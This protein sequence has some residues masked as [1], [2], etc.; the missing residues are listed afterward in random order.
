MLDA[1]ATCN[2][3]GHGKPFRRN[4]DE[5]ALDPDE[6]FG[7]ECQT[8]ACVECGRSTGEAL[9]YDR[10]C[11]E[12]RNN[13]KIEG[14]T[15]DSN[16]QFEQRDIF[17]GPQRYPEPGK[18][19]KY[20]PGEEY[21]TLSYKNFEIKIGY[22]YFNRLV[23]YAHVGSH[24]SCGEIVVTGFMLEIL[25]ELVSRLGV[26]SAAIRGSSECVDQFG[27]GR[28]LHYS[29]ERAYMENQL[30]L[31]SI[32]ERPQRKELNNTCY[33]SFVDGIENHWKHESE[34]ANAHQT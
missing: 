1:C 13:N 19:G 29:E 21:V 14:K 6:A 16:H 17:V 20:Q 15:M 24:D 25:D 27:V 28:A 12:C 7:Y 31:F 3:T 23:G 2:G 18:P 4:N 9:D 10:L 34:Y 8:C 33:E 30:P 26:Q 22:T 32:R 5:R 11:G